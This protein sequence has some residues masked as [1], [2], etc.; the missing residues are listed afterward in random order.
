M[1]KLSRRRFLLGSLG[2]G[3]ATAGVG[4][5][6]YGQADRLSVER[7]TLK[8]PRWDAN[9]FKIG[10]ISDF[11]LTTQRSVDR[12][13]AALQLCEQEK[14][15]V[16][17]LGGDYTHGHY[18]S[19]LKH[20]EALLDGIEAVQI[21]VVG[22]LGNHDY[23][24]V[25]PAKLVSTLG[26][27]SL[28]LLRNQSTEIGGV[29]IHGIDD[30]IAGR[31]RHD[32]LGFNHDK[33]SV[34]LFH[35]PDMV[36]DID[37]RFSLMLAGHS[38]GGQICMPFGIPVHT[39]FGARTYIKGFYPDARIP[40]YVTRGVGTIGVDRRAFCPPEVSILTLESA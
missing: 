7:N 13:L 33:N 21:P 32:N 18:R 24:W 9:G 26:N 6:Q 30:A 39:P 36:R 35:E 40:L 3:I 4:A 17:A 38:H 5:Y 8:L 37:S 27:R 29:T 15:D 16:I 12:T 20:V 10:F 1:S 34:C 23:W 22:I 2:A 14:P 31:D 19:S 28:R 11:H 25:D